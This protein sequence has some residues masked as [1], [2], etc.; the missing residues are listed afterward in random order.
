[1]SALLLL[2]SIK[3]DYDPE[4]IVSVLNTNNVWNTLKTNTKNYTIKDYIEELDL[5][6]GGK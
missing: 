1:M 4:F 2:C 3:Y 6:F 5:L